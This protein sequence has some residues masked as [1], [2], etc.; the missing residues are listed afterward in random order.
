[1]L[2]NRIHNL[3]FLVLA[4]GFAAGWIFFDLSIWFFVALLIVSFLAKVYASFTIGS[5]YYVPVICNG[6]KQH[7]AVAL[8]FD[9]APVP[10]KTNRILDIL[11]EKDVPATFFCIGQRVNENPDLLKRIDVE[12]HLV[13]NHSY[14]HKKTFPVQR[15]EK[16]I[17]ELTK[18]DRSIETLINKK[19]AYFRPPFGITNPIVAGAVLYTKHAV[20]GWNVRSLDTVTK[21]KKR[22]WKRITENLA[23][24]DIVLFHDYVDL[25]IEILPEYIDYIRK[26]GLKIVRLDALIGIKPY[27]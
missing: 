5:Q 11:K 25:T 9:D 10:D 17:A 21:N 15:L 18:T 27:A 3:V 8:T 22:L 16:I 6:N 20:I 19:P 7:Q 2:K 23:A 26:S 1:M 14:Y 4:I 13:G 12:G 24:G